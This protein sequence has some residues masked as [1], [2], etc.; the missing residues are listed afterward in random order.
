MMVESSPNKVI[1]NFL[2]IIFYSY[3]FINRNKGSENKW[4]IV[5]LG[6]FFYVIALNYSTF[7]VIGVIFGWFAGGSFLCYA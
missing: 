1:Y 2:F 3:T 7:R 5:V 4:D 6:V